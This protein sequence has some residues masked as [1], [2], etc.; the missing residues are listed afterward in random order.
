MYKSNRKSLDFGKDGFPK[1]GTGDWNDSLN[2]VGHKGEGE[3]V[4]LGFFLYD[5]LTR[6]E[7]ILEIKDE[8]GKIE[9][10]REI[11]R[12]LKRN[13]NTEA[14][15]GNWYKRAITDDGKV[16]GSN[17]N[18][19]GKID[20]IAQ[21]WAVISEAGENDKKYLALDSAKKYL[22]DEENKIIKLLT[23]AFKEDE[24]DPGYIKRYPVGVRKW[25]TIYAQ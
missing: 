18:K 19:E 17:K 4:W 2:K 14:W 3:S 8:N 5:I 22:V 15:D 21:S 11:A 9:K 7:K 10:Y 25:R 1:I 12:Q 13:L 6:W 23:P 24:L 20:S 16:I